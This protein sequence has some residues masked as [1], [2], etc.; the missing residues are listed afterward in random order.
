MIWHKLSHHIRC[1]YKHRCPKH[2]RQDKREYHRDFKMHW[3]EP[4]QSLEERKN[5]LESTLCIITMI[6]TSEPL[7]RYHKEIAFKNIFVIIQLQLKA[8][9]L[10]KRTKEQ[11]KI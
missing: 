10:Y 1:N 11:I 2:R 3:H 9:C 5:Q 4:S 8:D 6:M 7:I